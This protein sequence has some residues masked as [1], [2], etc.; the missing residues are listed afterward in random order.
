MS[1]SSN[2]FT[3]FRILAPQYH[4]G[5]LCPEYEDNPGARLINTAQV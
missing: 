4:N 5:K 2:Q 3:P 1:K